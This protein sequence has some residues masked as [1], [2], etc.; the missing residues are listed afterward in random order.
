MLWILVQLALE[1]VVSTRTQRQIETLRR[2]EYQ[3]YNWPWI[4]LWNLK[5]DEKLENFCRK[6]FIWK[7]VMQWNINTWPKFRNQILSQTFRPSGDD[8][9]FD[10]DRLSSTHRFHT[11]STPF[12]HPKSL[13]STPKTPQFHL[14]LSSTPKA[15]QFHTKNPSVQH[16]FC[17][18]VC[19]SEGFLVWNWGI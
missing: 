16:S 7:K 19:W 18:G 17:L 2:S 15:P 12:Q 14:L 11:R 8:P 13:S 6:N 4:Y 1:V 3:N 10:T 9:Q 5:F